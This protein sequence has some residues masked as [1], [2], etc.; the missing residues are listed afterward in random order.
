MRT[1]RINL[2]YIDEH[3]QPEAFVNSV[4]ELANKTDTDGRPVFETTNLNDA[5]NVAMKAYKL[6]RQ[7]LGTVELNLRITPIE[8][9][10]KDV[11]AHA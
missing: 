8:D 1:F 11:G 9:L 7:Y 5:M 6:C 3:F 2:P 10:E 4:L